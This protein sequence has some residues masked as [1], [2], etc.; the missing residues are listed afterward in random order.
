MPGHYEPA[1]LTVVEPRF[2]EEVVEG[3]RARGH[4]VE[5][6][7]TFDSLLGHEHAIELVHDDA[8]DTTFAAAADPR[9]EGQAAGL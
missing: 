2:R 4:E 9:S 1:T 7:G 5:L 6:A 3:L 8:T